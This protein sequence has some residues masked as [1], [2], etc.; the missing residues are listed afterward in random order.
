MTKP[1]EFLSILQIAVL[2]DLS[3][4][5][6]SKRESRDKKHPLPAATRKSS[7]RFRE[8]LYREDEIIAYYQKDGFAIATPHPTEMTLLEIA[9]EID[10]CPR[11]INRLHK[12]DPNFPKEVRQRVSDTTGRRTTSMFSRAEAA[13]YIK[14]YRKIHALRRRGIDEQARNSISEATGGAY[15]TFNNHLSR[16]FMMRKIGPQFNTR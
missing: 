6:V 8:K 7:M 13:P 9:I 10:C 5:C 16:L 3:F 4:S 1:S 11:I 2:F 12:T 14:A 15:E